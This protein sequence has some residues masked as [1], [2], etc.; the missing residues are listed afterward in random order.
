MPRKRRYDKRRYDVTVEL[1]VAEANGRAAW[2]AF[3]GGP[4]EALAAWEALRGR[5]GHH[6]GQWPEPAWWYEPGVPPALRELDPA[7]DDRTRRQ[8][9]RARA[10]WLVVSGRI[11]AAELAAARARVTELRRVV[12]QAPGVGV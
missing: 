12:A 9:E 7:L 8:A 5:Y 1:L 4:E 10:E 3:W 11:A 2:E 6:P